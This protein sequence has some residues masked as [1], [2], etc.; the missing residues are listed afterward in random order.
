MVHGSSCL[1]LPLLSTHGA[2]GADILGLEPLDDAMD[3]EHMGA[4]A[5][6]WRGAQKLQNIKGV[7]EIQ[8]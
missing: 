2:W 5:P 6:H 7:E 4:L 1:P 8:T 3:V